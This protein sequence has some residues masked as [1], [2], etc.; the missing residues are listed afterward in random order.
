MKRKQS[1][2]KKQPSGHMGHGDHEQGGHHSVRKTHYKGF[3]IE[4]E[5]HYKFK[6]DGKPLDVHAH[7]LNSGH[8]HSA[9]LPNYGWT[10]AVDFVRQ[11]IDSFPDDFKPQKKKK[12][13]KKK[14]TKKKSTK[15]KASKKKSSKKK[16]KSRKSSRKKSRRS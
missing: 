3:E 7:V 16:S 12:S 14:P 4:V 6:V 15:R 10:S 5:T 11:L 8:V 9:S 1:A 2:A 13:S